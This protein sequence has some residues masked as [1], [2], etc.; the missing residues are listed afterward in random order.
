LTPSQTVWTFG[1]QPLCQIPDIA[2]ESV[3]APFELGA[4]ILAQSGRTKYRA[5]QSS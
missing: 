1:R 3:T 4:D 5:W 2:G